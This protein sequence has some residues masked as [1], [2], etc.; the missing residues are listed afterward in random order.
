M[1]ML[2]HQ[3]LDAFIVAAEIDIMLGTTA[4]ISCIES[5]LL[6]LLLL[7]LSMLHLSLCC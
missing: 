1:L 6:L 5:L 2:L 4:T 7:L 3:L